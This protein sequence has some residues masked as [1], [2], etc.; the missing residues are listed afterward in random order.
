MHKF[1]RPFAISGFLLVLLATAPASQAQ[2]FT[3]L[4]SLCSQSNCT[5][6]GSPWAGLVQSTDGNLYGTTSGGGDS[7]GGVIFKITPSGTLTTL[8]GFCSQSGC[9]DGSDP[10]AGLVQGRNGNLYGATAYG[11]AYGGAEGG[12]G[13][14]FEFAR[15]GELTTLL[16]FDFT[17]GADPGGVIQAGDAKFYGTTTSGGAYNGGTVFEVTPGGDLTTLYSF[18]HREPCLDGLN[19]YSGLV[20]ASNGDFYGTTYQGGSGTGCPAS[21]KG[22]GTVFKITASGRLTV[23]HSFCVQSGCPDGSF[24]VAGL[25]QASDGNLYGTTETGGANTCL[26]GTT[27]F[28]CG[29]IFKI[30]PSGAFKV[31]Y[32]FCSVSGCADGSDPEAAL[33]QG[34]DGNLYGTTDIGGANLSGT[35]FKVTTSGDLTTLYTFCSQTDCTDGA[36]PVAAL[37]QDTNGVFYGTT[38][39]GGTSSLCFFGCGT[40]FSVSVDL[41]PFVTLLPRSGKIG[42]SMGI[43]GTDLTSATSVTFSGVSAKFTVGSSS[44]ITATVPAGATTGTVQVV[45]PGGTLSSNVPFRVI[46]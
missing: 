13:T 36:Q 1:K 18:C 27:N 14:A 8:Y 16:S 5:D 25:V 4:Y 23:L 17:D 42:A 45:T 22:C 3:S 19:P 20:Q 33:V 6:G 21:I 41:G 39:L 2:T 46:Q 40:V 30:N 44:L 35:I 31:I 37:V 43:L 12:Y 26:I 34:T 7:G 38:L 24:P 29:A 10:I 28:G 32:S 9:L 11:G 15:S